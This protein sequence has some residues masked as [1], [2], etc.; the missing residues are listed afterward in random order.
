MP[1]LILQKDDPASP[2]ARKLIDELDRYHE[3]LYPAAS[4][5]LLSVEALRAPNVTFITARLDDRVVGCG[6]FVNQDG[7]YAEIKRMYVLPE[8]RGMKIGRRVLEELESQA[9]GAGL[10]HAMLET[11]V[12]QLAAIQ[13]Y[14]KAAMNVAGRLA[15]TPKIPY[16]SS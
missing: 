1:G 2:E 5:H 9:R 10:T 7:L 14:Q 6:A 16:V 8:C 3:S 12:H 4:N 13:C 11:G 15:R